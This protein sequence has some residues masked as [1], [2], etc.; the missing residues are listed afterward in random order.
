MERLHLFSLV[1]LARWLQ[2]QQFRV[3]QALPHTGAGASAACGMVLMAVKEM[4][5]AQ[6]LQEPNP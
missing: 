6:A 2:T 1:R 4:L 3:V 5:A